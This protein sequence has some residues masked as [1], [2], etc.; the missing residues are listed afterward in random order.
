MKRWKLHLSDVYKTRQCLVLLRATRSWDECTHG[1]PSVAIGLNL[2]LVSLSQSHDTRVMVLALYTATL[3]YS[4]S[5]LL[6][7]CWSHP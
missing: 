4:Q 2:N 6:N 7:F 5:D 3:F 1:K